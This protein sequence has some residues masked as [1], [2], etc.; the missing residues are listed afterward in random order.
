[1]VAASPAHRGQV[2][3]AKRPRRMAGAARVSI[4]PDGQPGLDRPLVQEPGGSPLLLRAEAVGPRKVREDLQQDLDGRGR[5]IE[6]QPPDAHGS[7]ACARPTGPRPPSVAQAIWWSRAA[8]TRSRSCRPRTRA[9]LP[10][11]RLHD[12]AH[13]READARAAAGVR[14]RDRSTRCSRSQISGSSS[15]GI[16]GPVFS[17]AQRN[18]PPSAARRTVIR[19]RRRCSARRSA[20]GWRRPG[21]WRPASA[22]QRRQDGIRALERTCDRARSSSAMRQR[23]GA[24]HESPQVDLARPAALPARSLRASWSSPSTSRVRRSISSWTVRS[25]SGVGSTTPSA[26]ASV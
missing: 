9:N 7:Q 8:G 10:T 25:I 20:P 26:S 23:Q 6:R 17:I 16:S 13:D 5:T 11:V 14:A 3:A 24:P 15:A 2:G 18:A 12:L 1:M 22:D 4:R 19:R 21:R